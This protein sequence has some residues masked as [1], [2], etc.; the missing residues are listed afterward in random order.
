[1]K[2]PSSHFSNQWQRSEHTTVHR[3]IQIVG[4]T[5]ACDQNGERTMKVTI[6]SIRLKK[7]LD[8]YE[9]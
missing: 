3:N 7:I 1:M 2:S 9:I 6:C 4:F 8:Q 5:E